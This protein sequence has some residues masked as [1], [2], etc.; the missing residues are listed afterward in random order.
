MHC[1]LWKAV[2]FQEYFYPATIIICS[3]VCL[4]V[5]KAILMRSFSSL[6]LWTEVIPYFGFY[7][8]NME[9][10]SWMRLKA[11]HIFRLTLKSLP[12]RFKFSTHTSLHLIH[13]PEIPFIFHTPNYIVMI[14]CL[15]VVK[16][17]IMQNKIREAKTKIQLI[18]ILF[19]RLATSWSVFRDV[20]TIYCVRY[21]RALDILPYIYA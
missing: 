13:K 18:R 5:C 9:N 7:A 19:I 2:K 17:E 21:T 12:I 6:N 3:S 16:S 4:H 8:L 14:H 10:I 1:S 11:V 15:A 20:T